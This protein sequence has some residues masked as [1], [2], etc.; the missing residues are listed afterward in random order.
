MQG[1]ADQSATLRVS[2]V[3]ITKSPSDAG[4]DNDMGA[5]N[6]QA[7]TKA[8]EPD[9]GMSHQSRQFRTQ[10]PPVPRGISETSSGTATSDRIDEFFQRD[11]EILCNSLEDTGTSD[12]LILYP[13]YVPPPVEPTHQQ[14][15]TTTHSLDPNGPTG[16]PV[17][18]YNVNMQDGKESLRPASIPL[19]P[20]LYIVAIN[21]DCKAIW[22]NHL[23]EQTLATSA[24]E[25]MRWDWGNTYVA[26][27]HKPLFWNHQDELLICG[28]CRDSFWSLLTPSSGVRTLLHWVNIPVFDISGDPV[29]GIYVGHNAT[30]NT[31]TSCWLLS[32]AQSL[33]LQIVQK[34]S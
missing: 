17:G 18:G 20:R 13:N 14:P 29:V 31:G 32:L 11:L 27:E 30:H 5:S 19:E 8:E 1:D 16:I 2:A 25:I 12:T 23:I 7:D 6:T 34:S 24:A 28:T 21:E 9:Q 26:P 33:P 10:V 3:E 4:D 15:Q 22:M